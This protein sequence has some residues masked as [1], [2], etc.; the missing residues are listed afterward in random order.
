MGELETKREQMRELV[1]EWRASGEAA[2]GFARRHG[3]TKDGFRYWRTRFG[4]GTTERE[5]RSKRVAFAAVRV[6]DDGVAPSVAAIEIRLAS[7]D[8]IRAGRD[9]P[10]ERLRSIIR[11]LRARC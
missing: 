10:V 2:A 9:L 6:V 8:V 1:R 5:A 11:M 4:R 3:M 7:G